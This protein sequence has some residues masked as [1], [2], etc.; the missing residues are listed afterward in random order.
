MDTPICDFVRAYRERNP[1]R[2]HMP[3]HKGIPFLGPE[4]LD[5]TEMTGADDLYHPEG[6]I[7]QSEENAAALFGSGKTCYST[8]GSSQCIRAM[9]Y[10][11]LQYAHRDGKNPRILAGRNEI[12]RAHV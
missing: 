4:P 11:A 7:A 3:G 9:L 1:M 5:L 8:E 2:L 6:I 10:L 12:G